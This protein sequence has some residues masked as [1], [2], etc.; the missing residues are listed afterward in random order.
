MS[1]YCKFLT[2]G[3]VY[4]NNTS[5]F[6]VAPCCY[7]SK[8]NNLDFDQNP[9]LQL[10]KYRE[11]WLKQDVATT[12]Q[13]CTNM[14]SSG[15]H[16]YRQASFD[17]VGDSDKIEI[18]T[19]AV[20]KQCNLACAS[21]GAHSSSYWYQENLRNNIA[22][23]QEIH[24]I[25]LDD[26]TGHTQKT[27]LSVLA[28]QDLTAL[29][30]I[31]FG[32]GEPLMS[33]THSEILELIPNPDQ[34]IVHYTSNFTIMPTDKVRDQWQKFKLIKWLASLDGVEDQFEF[35]R[36]PARWSMIQNHV[37]KAKQLVPHNVMFGVEHTLNP[38]N[39]YYYDR[40]QSWFE[41]N[42]ATNRYG[43]ASDFN[44]HPCFGIMDLKHTP[45]RLREKI[46]EK[47][48]EHHPIVRLLAENP[49]SGT[50]KSM[51]NYLDSLDSLRN[52]NW[53]KLFAEVE[54]YFD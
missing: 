26:R 27:F 31:K 43:D 3:L 24:Q 25:H 5:N 51:Q 1:S 6:V 18:L 38:L 34:V 30:Y 29:K 13:V 7:Y 44:L 11:L 39:I 12:C 52:S 16:S 17:L 4:N 28:E 54:E 49:Y 33:N 23:S 45:P 19:V 48:T 36:W 46:I 40:F 41:T 37:N 22:Q 14:E 50:A 35:L 20:N 47:Y 10:K 8:A 15:L 21:C 53:R 2:N 42:F 32:G 9:A